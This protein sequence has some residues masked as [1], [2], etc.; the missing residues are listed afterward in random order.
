MKLNISIFEFHT[1]NLHG[2]ERAQNLIGGEACVASTGIRS[3]T[4]MNLKESSEEFYNL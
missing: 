2:S 4:W 3:G 1:I